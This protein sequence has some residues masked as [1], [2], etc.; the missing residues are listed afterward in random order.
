M[1]VLVLFPLPAVP[2]SLRFFLAP[3]SAAAATARVRALSRFFSR[4]LPFLDDRLDGL[5]GLRV[6]SETSEESFFL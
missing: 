4:L 1:F 3:A 5:F 2:F 6:L